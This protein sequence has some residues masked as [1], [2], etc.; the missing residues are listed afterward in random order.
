MVTEDILDVHEGA[1]VALAEAELVST[2]AGTSVD[3][4]V[5]LD[6]LAVALSCPEH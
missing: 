5:T 3:A 2:R 4:N 6:R 1:I